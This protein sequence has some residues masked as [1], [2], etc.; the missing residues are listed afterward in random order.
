M[1]V[2]DQ[3]SEQTNR[4]L[5]FTLQGIQSTVKNYDSTV[6]VSA[7]RY[8]TDCGCLIPERRIQAIPTAIRC[9]KCQE[10]FEQK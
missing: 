3:T 10:V 4:H 9:V 5:N 8:C 2:C 7:V 6:P 1:D